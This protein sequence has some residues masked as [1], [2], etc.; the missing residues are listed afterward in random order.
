MRESGARLTAEKPP[1]SPEFI[2]SM[3]LPVTAPVR[4]KFRI[5]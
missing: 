3:G 5:T 2:R 4:K 1:D